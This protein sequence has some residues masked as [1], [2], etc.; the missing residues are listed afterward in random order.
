MRHFGRAPPAGARRAFQIPRRPGKVRPDPE[1]H[2]R[3]ETDMIRTETQAG[4]SGALS[5]LAAPPAPGE[6]AVLRLDDASRAVLR[7]D[8]PAR[9]IGFAAALAAAV[10]LAALTLVALVSPAA[11]QGYA[12]RPGD[13][14]QIEV[15]E[16]PDLNRSVLV[17]PDGSFSF[18]FAG[19]VDARGRTV[20]Q[21]RDELIQDLSG[22]FAAPPTVF[23]SVSRLAEREPVLPTTAAPFE[24]PTID[25]Y[26]TGEIANSGLIRVAPGTT[27]LQVIA[28]AGG[29][30]RFAADG[31]IQL[32][33]TDPAAG[34]TQAYL[35][36]FDGRRAGTISPATV[37]AEGDVVVVPERRL[38]EFD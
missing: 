21:I 27:I 11:A 9:S 10:V 1:S 22:A 8:T 30:T 18:P 4:P 34:R 7:L 16:D 14:L 36:D 13:V 2:A 29:L 24:E 37:L 17:T 12:V 23:V 19:S 35:F 26:V 20:T 32:R 28:Q 6:R 15:V 38:F 5:A 3:A 31:R 33:R 25:V